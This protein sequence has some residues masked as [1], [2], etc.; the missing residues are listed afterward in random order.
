MGKILNLDESKRYDLD[1]QEN[2]EINI[3]EGICVEIYENISTNVNI[4]VNISKK[5]SLVYH[6]FENAHD[7]IKINREINVFE[8]AS[9]EFKIVA[10]NKEKVDEK[11]LMRLKERNAKADYKLITVANSIRNKNNYDVSIENMAPQTYGNIWQKAVVLD[12]GE[13]NFIATGYID[14]GSDEAENFQE[15]RVLLLD[16]ASRGEASPFLLIE[17]Y[18]V[19]AGHKASVSRVS[20]EE[21]YYLQTRGIDKKNSENLLVKAFIYPLIEELTNEDYQEQVLKQVEENIYHA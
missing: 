3:A 4:S 15:S 16:D 9:L 21:M 17:H 5:S 19:L 14:P 11:I 10:L 6:S 1:L 12:G 18:N 13:S 8:K 20:E 2:V 7:S